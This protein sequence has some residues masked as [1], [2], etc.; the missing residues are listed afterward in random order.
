MALNIRVLG[1][2]HSWPIKKGLRKFIEQGSNSYVAQSTITKKYPCRVAINFGIVIYPCGTL[3]HL[4]PQRLHPSER[5]SKKPNELP[6]RGISLK[7]FSKSK[8]ISANVSNVN[9]FLDLDIVYRPKYIV[10]KTIYLKS[11]PN[12]PRKDHTMSNYQ[13]KIS[14]IKVKWK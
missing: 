9:N 14:E 4:F 6:S 8:N 10:N 13:N 7:S 12:Y 3:L 5:Q 11:V 1:W 2:R